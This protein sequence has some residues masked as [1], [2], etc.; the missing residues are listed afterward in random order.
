MFIA[1]NACFRLKRKRISTWKQD[2]SLQDGWAYFVENGPY[3]EWVKK[4]KDQKEVSYI[5]LIC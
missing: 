1:I 3:H 5:V 2:A 4:M